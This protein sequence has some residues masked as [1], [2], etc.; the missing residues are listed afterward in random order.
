MSIEEMKE[1]IVRLTNEARAEA[2]LAPLEVLPELTQCAQDKAQDMIDNHYYGHNSPKYGSAE[3]M[4]FLYV[5]SAATAAENIAAWH[6]T[7]ESAFQSWMES[8]KGHREIILTARLTHIG[9]GIVEGADGG[10]WWV[11]H[12][13]R[14]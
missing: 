5:P 11:Q 1:E 8:T 2:G 9:V 6:T 10:Y 3:D 12:F 7:P 13:A 14:I 4:I